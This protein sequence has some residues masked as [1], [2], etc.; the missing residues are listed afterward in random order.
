[1]LSAFSPHHTGPGSDCDPTGPPASR[2]HSDFRGKRHLLL[3]IMVMGTITG[4]A[5]LLAIQQLYQA[6]LLQQRERLMET[7][8][9]QARL[10][11]AVARFDA[12][13]AHTHQ[14][15]DAAQA[16]L[17]QIIEALDS[18]E[19]L[20]RTGGIALARREGDHVRFLYQQRDSTQGATLRVPL[21][22][23]LAEPMRR[24][25]E[26]L[27]GSMVGLD[28]QG[29]QVL[30]A[31]EPVA[32]LDLGIVTR[33]SMTEIRA[34]YVRAGLLTGLCTLLLLA[35]GGLIFLR[36]G[37][38]FVTEL[39][40]SERRYRELFDN[41]QDLVCVL[42]MD[43][44]VKDANRSLERMTGYD[45]NELLRRPYLDL[46]RERIHPE[47][48]LPTLASVQRMI[49]EA[50]PTHLE[51][52]VRSADGGYRNIAWNGVP[53]P[54]QRL[55]FSIGRD[56]TE[57]KRAEQALAASERLSRATLNGLSAHIVIVENDGTIA[58]VNDAWRRFA[59][60]NPPVSGN[61][62]EGANYFQ[63]CESALTED[64]S[65]GVFL[66]GLKAVM[67]GQRDQFELEYPCHSPDEQRWFIGRITRVPDDERGRVIIAHENITQRKRAEESLRET[68]EKFRN[69]S[70]MAQDAIIMMDHEGNFSFWNE[71]AQHIFGYTW[72]EVAGRPVHQLLA[73]E[74]YHE[75]FNRA[76]A[77]FQNTGQGKAVGQTLEL[78]AVRK[79][80]TE[81]PVE[82]S[83]SSFEIKG[84][85]HAMAI[86][87]DIS[88]RKRAEYALQA[89]HE[90]VKQL[91]ESIPSVLITLD[92]DRRVRKWNSEAR[93][94]LG[95]KEADI[96]N[97]PLE[98]L[99]LAW[100]A[101]EI[102]RALDRCSAEKQPVRIDEMRL[103][104][105]EAA[106]TYV[107]AS[108]IPLQP[109]DDH[110]DHYLILATD[111]T[112]MK[113]LQS[114]LV[115]AQRLESVGQLAAGIAHEI[116]TPTQFVSDNV[117]FLNK[118][119]PRFQELL[120]Q[121][122]RVIEQARQGDIPPTLLEEV[123]EVVRRTKPEYLLEQIPEAISDSL[124]GL[125]RVTRIVRA[126]KDFSHPGQ[127]DCTAADLNKAIESTVTVARN[128]W[129]YVAEMALDLD[130]ELPTVPCALGDIN[131]VILN[132]VINAAHAIAEAR[133][134]GGPEKG[135]ITVSTRRDG[136]DVEIRI[137]DTGT[138]IP[139]E[140]RQRI[141]EHFYTTKTV[142]KGTGQGLALARSIIVEKH[143]G[144]LTFETE[145]G[146]GTTFIIRLPM[147]PESSDKERRPNHETAHSLCG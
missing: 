142:G 31:Y 57:Q 35:A 68:A 28:H 59:R 6:A 96:I 141:F 130:P 88:E 16:T 101:S 129:K 66:Q 32:H 131:Q 72:E 93:R 51:H 127:D 26:G 67:A 38:P 145:T 55:M 133:N 75:D 90:E 7:A 118:A 45:R 15:D 112:S 85:W 113:A 146:Q 48:L 82:L 30:A 56:I 116:N 64:E 3:A 53:L 40:H 143:G 128:E 10:I 122:G 144:Q 58:E 83:L 29:R 136:D 27:S 147:D 33:I 103:H 69:M 115:Q 98:K 100:N 1:M 9:A 94:L 25:L 123:D 5:A 108:I 46:F 37:Y 13:H 42:G 74:F 119:L 137:R 4:A 60:E 39:Q 105:A 34:P 124:E 117:R 78:T 125:D 52:R 134:S 138:G 126:M 19:G 71:A 22:S 70:A 76:F 86:M 107:T 54:D 95:Y 80:G 20:G 2:K 43:G 73:P 81:C 18:F 139:E 14:D 62:C 63:A 65:A 89:A 110:D 102:A 8:H 61:V 79:D 77:H 132:I 91:L 84:Q 97:A 11:E 99:D 92:R 109:S 36:V 120:N 12:A 41:T 23:A 50:Q 49:D 140:H 135:T 44:Y 47:D 106:D 121:Y 111:I 87:R 24:A 17:S 104:R 21:D 114:Q